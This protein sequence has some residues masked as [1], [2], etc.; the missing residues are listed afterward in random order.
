ML[1]IEDASIVSGEVVGNDLILQRHDGTT[2]NAG[3]VRGPAGPITTSKLGDLKF[4]ALEV[5]DPGWAL[6]D[7]GTETEG[8]LYSALIAAG[9]PYG[10]FEGNPRRPDYRDRFPVGAGTSYDAGDTG[11]ANSVTLTLAQTPPHFH[12]V[13]LGWGVE[14]DVASNLQMISGDGP[15]GSGNF[16]TDSKGSG[17][18]HENRPPFLACFVYIYTLD[19]AA[20]GEGGVPITVLTQAEY[21]ALGTPDPGTIYVIVG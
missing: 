12:T 10:T 20:G 18:S 5:T 9:N 14:S 6:C 21:D 15:Y 11:G 19:G 1:Q 3:D 8:A 7:G 16:N 13:N 2:V 17:G 4:K